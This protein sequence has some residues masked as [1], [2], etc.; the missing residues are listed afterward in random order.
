MRGLVIGLI[1]FAAMSEVLCQSE[2]NQ[3]LRKRKIRKKVRV[4]PEVRLKSSGNYLM[5]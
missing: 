3:V 4:N 1:A 5:T 2:T